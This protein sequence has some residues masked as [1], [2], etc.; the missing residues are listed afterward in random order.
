MGKIHLKYGY[1]EIQKNKRVKLSEILNIYEAS[2]R[3]PL[4]NRNSMK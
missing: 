1:M 4:L 2:I 3:I